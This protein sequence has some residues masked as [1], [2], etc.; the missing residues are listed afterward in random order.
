MLLLL[1]ALCHEFVCKLIAA[2]MI[3]HHELA[4]AWKFVEERGFRK[5]L[6]SRFP[7]D[8]WTW[9]EVMLRYLVS[10]SPNVVTEYVCISMTIV[11]PTKFCA[12]RKVKI[13]L[14]VRRSTMT[15]CC[16]RVLE[17]W[18]SLLL[19]VE[20]SPAFSHCIPLI[21]FNRFFRFCDTYHGHFPY[22]VS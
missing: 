11:A 8:E 3:N 15:L 2:L 1:L 4:R 14:N 13:E 22:L 12:I 19:L 18:M 16:H 21:W 6:R 7:S 9:K 20:K 17:T 10:L 5:Q